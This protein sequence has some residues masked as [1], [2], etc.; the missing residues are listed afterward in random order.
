MCIPRRTQ[1]NFRSQ[2]YM[3]VYYECRFLSVTG[4]TIYLSEILLTGDG[5]LALFT[6]KSKSRR[7][8]GQVVVAISI[9]HNKIIYTWLSCTLKVASEHFLISPKPRISSYAFIVYYRNSVQKTLFQLW[10]S[11][12]INNLWIIPKF[13]WYVHL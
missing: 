9:V 4:C 2:Q 7:K 1:I 12:L 6:W 5:N 13:T 10:T 11:A 3:Y 8:L